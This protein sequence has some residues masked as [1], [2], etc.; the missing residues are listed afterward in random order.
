MRLK[1]YI[2]E[3]SWVKDHMMEI[4]TKNYVYTL[5]KALESWLLDPRKPLVSSENLV[6]FQ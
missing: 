5:S 2:L 3:H 6:I 4:H 1:F